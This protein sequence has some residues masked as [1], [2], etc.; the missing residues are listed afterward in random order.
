MNFRVEAKTFKQGGICGKP[1]CTFL[2]IYNTYMQRVIKTHSRA[3][4]LLFKLHYILINT[5]VH[6]AHERDDEIVHVSHISDVNTRRHLVIDLIEF[7]MT[8]A[9]LL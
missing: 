5:L 1:H 2:Y 9:K 3:S 4:Q 6:C 7:T 8:R